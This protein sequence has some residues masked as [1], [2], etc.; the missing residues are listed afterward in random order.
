MLSSDLKVY[1]SLANG[2][3]SAVQVNTGVVQNVFPHV[4]SAQRASGM[5]DYAK[6]HWK[7]GDTGNATLLD[8]EVYQDY[9]TLSADDYVVMCLLGQRDPISTLATTIAAADKAGSAILKNNITAGDS[10]CTVTVKHA[11][12]LPGGT[13]DIFLDGAKIKVCTHTTATGSDGAEETQTISGTPTYSGLDVTI[14]IAATFTNSY[15]ADGS[16]ARVSSLL[17]PA[18]DI[19]PSYTTPVVTSTAG[20]FDDTTYPVTLDNIG[21]VEEDITLTWTDATHFTAS[22]DTLGTLG[23]GTVGTTF[24]VTNSDFSRTMF[25]IHASALGGAWVSGDT[26][27]FTLHPATVPIGQKRVVSAGAA[28]LANNKATQV[29]GGEAS[30]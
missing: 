27:T 24:T 26:V 3:C 12:L 5:T 6:T 10:T 7:C 9:P 1:S 8:P 28:S 4:T 2:R 17:E 19:E 11:D 15:T 22:G 25:E 14:T 21:T 30:A 16:V 18:S 29:F 23:S 13:D 20:T